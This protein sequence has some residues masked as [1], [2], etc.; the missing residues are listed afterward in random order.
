MI[1][2][3]TQSL[4]TESAYFNYSFSKQPSKTSAI[5]HRLNFN[6]DL[7]GLSVNTGFFTFNHRKLI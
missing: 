6:K 3:N 1:N 5:S 4:G 7:K 2:V